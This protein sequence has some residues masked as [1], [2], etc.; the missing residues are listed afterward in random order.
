[1]S[2]ISP[3]SPHCL[4]NDVSCISSFVFFHQAVLVRH[5]TCV[6]VKQSDNA[7]RSQFQIDIKQV[8][9]TSQYA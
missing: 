7:K 6:Y 4:P 9:T 5:E 8:D 2:E 1:M 3:R